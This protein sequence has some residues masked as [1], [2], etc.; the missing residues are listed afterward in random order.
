[1]SMAVDAMLKKLGEI[2]EQAGNS[3]VRHG[4]VGAPTVPVDTG[5]AGALRLSLCTPIASSLHE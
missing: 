2:L 5:E 3:A 1:M 4:S